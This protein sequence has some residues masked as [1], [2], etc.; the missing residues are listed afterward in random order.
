MRR[1]VVCFVFLVAAAGAEDDDGS[2]MVGNRAVGKHEL[3][4]RQFQMWKG[5]FMVVM[6]ILMWWSMCVFLCASVCV[7]VLS[8]LF[9]IKPFVCVCGGAFDLALA[10]K[11]TQPSRG[12]EEKR[13]RISRSSCRRQRS[14]HR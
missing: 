7:F 4:K 12:R 8:L 5:L 6:V 13:E 3:A 11:H 9:R 2:R 1:K 14:Y 10:N